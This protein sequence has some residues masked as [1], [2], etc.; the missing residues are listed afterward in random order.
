MLIDVIVTI[1]L[2]AMMGGAIAYIIRSKKRGETCVGCPYAKECAMK[3]QGSYNCGGCS[4]SS[5]NCG[6]MAHHADLGQ[7]ETAETQ[8]DR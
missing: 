2:V 6:G 1:I 7:D 8:S 4:C 5:Y 3:R